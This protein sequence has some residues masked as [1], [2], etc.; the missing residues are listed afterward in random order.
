MLEYKIAKGAP[1]NVEH[2]VNDA[3][4]EG[5][6]LYGSPD[7]YVANGVQFVVQAM[8][9]EFQETAPAQAV[10]EADDADDADKRG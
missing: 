4:R 2:D 10:E 3:L 9:R 7:V 5:W 1:H 6:D 8:T